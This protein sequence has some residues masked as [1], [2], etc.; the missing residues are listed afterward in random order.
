[1][2]RHEL[3]SEFCKLITVTLGGDYARPGNMSDADSNLAWDVTY[4]TFAHPA[5]QSASVGESALI[6]HGNHCTTPSP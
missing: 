5:S 6:L 2:T 1:M 3:Y 4:T